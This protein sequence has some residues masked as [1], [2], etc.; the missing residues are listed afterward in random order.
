MFTVVVLVVFVISFNFHCSF[1]FIALSLFEFA[2]G[3]YILNY[4]SEMEKTTRN[5]SKNHALPVGRLGESEVY[6]AEKNPLWEFR[7]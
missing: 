3:A 5:I 6:G 4:T 1:F 7:R 2:Y